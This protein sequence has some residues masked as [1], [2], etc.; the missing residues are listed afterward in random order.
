MPSFSLRART[1][2]CYVLL[3]ESLVYFAGPWGAARQWRRFAN[4]FETKLSLDEGIC[5]HTPRWARTLRTR[6]PR[7]LGTFACDVFYCCHQD[8]LSVV[9]D[10]ELLR[11]AA[12]RKRLQYSEGCRTR[13]RHASIW[14]PRRRVLHRHPPLPKWNAS[15]RTF[16]TLV[17][18]DFD[19]PET[20]FFLFSPNVIVTTCLLL[21]VLERCMCGG[22]VKGCKKST[23]TRVKASRRS[24]ALKKS[25]TN[26]KP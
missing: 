2:A 7:T 15:E 8:K 26:K 18:F 13:F 17:A 21:N 25:K 24:L 10:C 1:Y 19:A 22:D 11:T 9:L 3:G 20:L 14:I 6:A 16:Q 12:Q 23:S 5:D 4:Y